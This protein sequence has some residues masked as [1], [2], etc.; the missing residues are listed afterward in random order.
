MTK[1]TRQVGP[2]L[3]CESPDIATNLSEKKQSF[4]AYFSISMNGY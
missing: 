4:S 1:I 2:P 3:S